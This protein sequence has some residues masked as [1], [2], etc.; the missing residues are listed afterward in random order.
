MEN[1]PINNEAFG[2]VRL[3]IPEQVDLDDFIIIEKFVCEMHNSLLP[4]GI[5][6]DGDLRKYVH[7]KLKEHSITITYTHVDDIVNTLFEFLFDNN[8]LLPIS[9]SI[10]IENWKDWE[11]VLQKS[12]RDFTTS[13][14]FAPNI[15]NL[16][17][18]TKSQLELVSGIQILSFYYFMKTIGK[19]A[20]IY[21]LKFCLDD[22]LTDKRIVLEYI[23]PNN[24]DDD[25]DFPCRELPFNTPS[26]TSLTESY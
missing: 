11:Q 24:D 16:S 1:K 10:D 22:S 23:S 7:K 26:P 14:G 20:N 21:P 4:N 3:H 19:E 8:T 5:Y 9:L 18:Y 2:Y 15:L 25:N 17:T 12:I 13:Y 6:G